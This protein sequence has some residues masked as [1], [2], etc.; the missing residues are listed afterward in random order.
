MRTQADMDLDVLAEIARKD[1]RAKRA[2]KLLI[3]W[4]VVA[5]LLPFVRIRLWLA[6]FLLDFGNLF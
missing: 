5:R 3:I 4:P 2:K 6:N 1:F